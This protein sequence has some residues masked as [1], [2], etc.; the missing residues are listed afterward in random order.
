VLIA[1]KMMLENGRLL[2]I[3]ETAVV[4]AAQKQANLLAQKV[5]A[6]PAHKSLALIPPMQAGKL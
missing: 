6:D 2:T 3:D 1:G 5:S 4:T